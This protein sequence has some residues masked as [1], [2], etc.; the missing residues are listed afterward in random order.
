MRDFG[1][2]FPSNQ[3]KNNINNKNKQIL[4]E[5]Y[6]KRRVA[7]KN[8][9]EEKDLSDDIDYK[10]LYKRLKKENKKVIKENENLK[11][12]NKMYSTELKIIKNQ[13]KI[14]KLD[15]FNLRKENNSIA[16]ENNQ[17][18]DYKLSVSKELIMKDKII[19]EKNT[20]IM[21][22]INKVQSYEKD[23]KSIIQSKNDIVKHTE[24]IRTKV[25]KIP[26][27]E[28]TI[29]KLTKKVAELHGKI[30]ILNEEIKEYQ[31]ISP[32]T[33][34]PHLYNSLNI[35]NVF[36]YNILNDL[37]RKYKLTKR[38]AY[39]LRKGKNIKNLED[40][41]L[42]GYL[43]LKEEKYNFVDL[44]GKSYK[45][46]YLPKF[47]SITGSPVS[48]FDN[49]DGTVDVFWNYETERDMF[50]DVKENKKNKAE[51]IILE[52]T[53]VENYDFIGDF[54]VLIVTSLNG[55]RYRNRLEKHGVISTSIDPFEKS[56]EHI[57]ILMKSNDIVLICT[58]NI[59]HSVL[60]FIEEGNEKYQRIANHN[61]E[62]IVARTRYTAKQLGLI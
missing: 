33:I 18:N 25:K 38:T 8:E 12:I 7:N 46:N 58:D 21:N 45:I 6:T 26:E 39:N 43:L 23:I 13:N 15:S 49:R 37:I 28:I 32:T 16:K 36:D 35:D 51:N 42:F 17:V 60:N 2:D 5:K 44:K 62:R 29:E 52:K 1:N 47:K 22:L 48:A 59:P 56:G 10:K 40:D 14:L 53:E 41:V 54:R 20:E 3:R 9:I 4:L 11:K 19:E 57:H 50:M 30:K 55:V 27:N 31:S 24:K 61:E 34:L